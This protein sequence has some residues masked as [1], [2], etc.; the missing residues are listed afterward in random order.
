MTDNF[1]LIEPT[2]IKATEAWPV[3]CYHG[4]VFY[5]GFGRNAWQSTW[6][7]R[8]YPHSISFDPAELKQFAELRRVQGSVF[9]IKSIPL[10]ILQYPVNT[11]GLCAI[12]D[13]SKSEYNALKKMIRR[14]DPRQFWQHLPSSDRNWMLL[15]H[16]GAPKREEYRP[17]RLSSF[18]KGAAYLLGWNKVAAPAK[19]FAQFQAFAAELVERL[20]PSSGPNIH[21]SGRDGVGAEESCIFTI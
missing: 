21:D 9:H 1:Q 16:L 12:N 8:Y 2:S 6:I 15:F 4:S 7:N 17:F 5:L 18:S 19:D 3:D 10:L 20:A 13:R 11:F 14:T